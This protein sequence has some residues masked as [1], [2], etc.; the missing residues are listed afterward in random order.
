MWGG[1]EE[2]ASQEWRV[3]VILFIVFA[4]VHVMAAMHLNCLLRSS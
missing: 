1:R 4:V 3:F 2:A